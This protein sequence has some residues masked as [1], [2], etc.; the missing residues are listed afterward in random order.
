MFKSCFWK[1]VFHVIAIY[2]IQWLV[3]FLTSFGVWSSWFLHIIISTK[4]STNCFLKIRVYRLGTNL[5][6]TGWSKPPFFCLLKN[7]NLWNWNPKHNQKEHFFQ[8]LGW[9]MQI[10]KRTFHFETP[11][12]D[13][14]LLLYIVVIIF[15][16]GLFTRG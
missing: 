6:R 11:C 12:M 16:R 10:S 8:K 14:W 13:K 15:Q 5:F 2:L 1:V 9:H 4:E 3:L 7:E